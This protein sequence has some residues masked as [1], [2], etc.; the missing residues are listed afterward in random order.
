MAITFEKLGSYGQLG[1]QMF[2]YAALLGIKH[3]TGLDVAFSK[4]TRNKSYLFN[5]FE[6]QE[7]IL[8]EDIAKKT[9]IEK[10]FNFDKEVFN[11]ENQTNLEG[12]FQSEKY[13][14]HCENHVRKE[15]SFLPHILAEAEKIC[16]PYDNSK[17]VSIH[18]RRGD[19]LLNP[20]IHTTLTIDYYNTAIQ[21]FPSN[22]TFLCFSDD[23]EWCK[24]YI[25][26]DN[27]VFTN[28]PL[29][30]D[31]CAMSMCGH[32]IIANSTFSWWGAWLNKNHDKIV[33]SP[34]AR[35][36]FGPAN[37]V[38]TDDLLPPNF[39]QIDNI[40]FTDNKSKKIFNTPYLNAVKEAAR[41]KEK[42][43]NLKKNSAITNIFEHLSEELGK[44]MATHVEDNYPHSINQDFINRFKINDNLGN[45]FKVELSKNFKE[46]SPSTMRYLKTY[47]EI[48][49][50]CLDSMEDSKIVEIGSG[51]GGLCTVISQYENY[52]NYTLIDLP[53]LLELSEAYLRETSCKADKIKYKTSTRAL[54]EIPDSCQSDIDLVIA[55]YSISVIDKDMQSLYIKNILRHSKHGYIIY[56]DIGKTF[57]LENMDSNEFIKELSKYFEVKTM[58]ETLA[59]GN[60]I[61]IYW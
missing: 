30:V 41:C 43:N 19:Y 12:Y 31:L 3:R 23:I 26:A 52:Q 14:R 9:Y 57:N 58:P 53:E 45:A 37:P 32:N 21:M 54:L 46:V 10:T 5:F 17:L 48:K 59:T 50:Y 34:S 39:I 13:F 15:F 42:F 18:V 11:I 22:Y 29:E 47:L 2:Q 33:I 8:E 1:N 40:P 4:D 61:I 24:K 44:E 35:D 6:L 55:C 16:K 60:N 36:W 51:Y 20:H 28:N 56:N 38:N 25:H 27:I 7:Y 49:K